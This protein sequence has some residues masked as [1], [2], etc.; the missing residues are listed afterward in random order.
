ML[1][2]APTVVDAIWQSFAA[3]LQRGETNHP[4]GLSS[5]S[6]L[7]SGLLRGHLVPAGHRVLLGRGGP[8]GEGNETTLPSP[9]G[10]VGCRRC[11][12]TPGRRSHQRGSTR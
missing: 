11:I 10:R 3:Y 2:L 9:P 12:R 1:A 6:D 5:T 7:G 8:A 4:L